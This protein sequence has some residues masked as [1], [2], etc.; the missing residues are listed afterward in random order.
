MIQKLIIPLVMVL[1]LAGMISAGDVP[2]APMEPWNVRLSTASS[3]ISMT[4]ALSGYFKMKADSI[5]GGDNTGRMD[6]LYTAAIPTEAI[7]VFQGLFEITAQPGDSTLK[8]DSC[9]ISGYTSLDGGTVP[10]SVSARAK[11]FWCDTI[12]IAAAGTTNYKYKSIVSND[13]LFWPA[14]YFLIEMRD[15]T[16]VRTRTTDSLKNTG[17][18]KVRLSVQVK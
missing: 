10:A 5:A 8:A 18:Y 17:R 2:N 16:N 14:S 7:K 15:S 6:S 13:T 1:C 11:L 9:I 12:V 3:H 4:D